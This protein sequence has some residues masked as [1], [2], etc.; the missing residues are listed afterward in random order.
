MTYK[1]AIEQSM[2]MLAR[3]PLVR[4]CGYG[5]LKGKNGCGMRDVPDERICE[6]TVAEGLM[7]SA[8]IGMSLMGLK[9]VVLLERADFLWNAMDAIVNHLDACET[10]SKGEFR[11]T[12]ILRIIIGNKHGPLFTGHTHTQDNS[13]ALKRAVRFP[14]WKARSSDEIFAAYEMAYKNLSLH[15]TAIYEEKDR[16]Q[17]YI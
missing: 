6:F 1:S 11:P 2:T 12:I 4:F 3:D 9:P 16:T 8:A 14:V 13:D 10:I 7:T 5:L 15:S 17:G